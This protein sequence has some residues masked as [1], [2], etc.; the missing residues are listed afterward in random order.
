MD[1]RSDQARMVDGFLPK[2]VRFCFDDEDEE[3]ADNDHN[4]DDQEN[5]DDD[6]VNYDKIY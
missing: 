4:Y 6:D 1:T 2:S 3:Y 5:Y